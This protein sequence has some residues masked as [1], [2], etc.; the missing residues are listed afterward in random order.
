MKKYRYFILVFS[1]L[2]MVALTILL[3]KPILEYMQDPAAFT[4]RLQSLGAWGPIVFM[5][6]NNAQVLLAII[7]G[8]PF[9]VA[10]V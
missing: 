5:A 8:G 6:L 9:D 10:A 3:G 2:L 4:L 7:P 1:I